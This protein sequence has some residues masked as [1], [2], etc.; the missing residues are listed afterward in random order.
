MSFQIRCTIVTGGSL[1]HLS[2][3]GYS[4]DP[5]S[6]LLL[7]LVDVPEHFIPCTVD[8]GAVIDILFNDT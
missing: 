3:C 8:N 2:G 5:S 4:V 7:I 1:S 6:R